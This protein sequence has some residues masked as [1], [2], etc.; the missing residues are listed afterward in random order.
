MVGSTDWT[1]DGIIMTR[2]EREDNN[3]VTIVFNYNSEGT[4]LM[5]ID[6]L[7][8]VSKYVNEIY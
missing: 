7:T 6:S 8:E 2:E 4:G 5:K 1:K 3:V